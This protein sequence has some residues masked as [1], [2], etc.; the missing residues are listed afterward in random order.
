M[1]R[2]R[3]KQRASA[4]ARREFLRLTGLVGTSFALSGIRMPSAFGQSRY[5]GTLRISVSRGLKTLNPI[6]HIS[7]PEY[8]YQVDVQQSYQT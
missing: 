2:K 4:I 1:G 3:K 8:G 7:G 5:G 6:M